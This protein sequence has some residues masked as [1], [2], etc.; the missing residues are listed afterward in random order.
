MANP[1]LATTDY[2]D[3]EVAKKQ[4]YFADVFDSETTHERELDLKDANE[5]TVGQIVVVPTEG[6]RYTNVLTPENS[7]DGANKKYVDDTV[8]DIDT[9]LGT[10]A[11]DVSLETQTTTE[12]V[13]E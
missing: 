9:I 3:G 11:N 2:V 12:G 4:E 13:D 8:G 10:M 5:N 7:T 6:I 1:K